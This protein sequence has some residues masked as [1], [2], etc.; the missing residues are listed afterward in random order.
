MLSSVCILLARAFLVCSRTSSRFVR[1]VPLAYIYDPRISVQSVYISQ[2][3]HSL[4][5]VQSTSTESLY[6][7]SRPSLQSSELQVFTSELLHESCLFSSWSYQL[8]IYTNKPLWIICSMFHISN[9]YSRIGL[10]SVYTC[11]AK[12]SN[13]VL[14]SMNWS[15]SGRTV[16]IIPQRMQWLA[17]NAVD[18]CAEA[19]Q[20]IQRIL[21]T[22]QNAAS[23]LKFGN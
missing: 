16:Q 7:A 23:H 18:F 13:L 19:I 11:Y 1:A 17:K 10:C 22:V 20:Q 12:E 4:T 8:H 5:R 15:A 2:R 21:K 6:F 3:P 9:V 14:K